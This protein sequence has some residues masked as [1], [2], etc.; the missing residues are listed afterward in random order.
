MRAG[1]D[2]SESCVLNTVIVMSN[3]AARM[4]RGLVERAALDSPPV[5]AKEQ[6]I[7]AVVLFTSSLPPSYGEEGT[8]DATACI[9][10]ATFSSQAD[11]NHAI[12]EAERQRELLRNQ[13][14]SGRT[15]QARRKRYSNRAALRDMTP[16]QRDG[17]SK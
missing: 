15:E 2:G 3:D 12:Y 11:C 7:K 17:G 14:N 5:G 9:L 10:P 4:H 6:S 16:S 13:C 1:D 8:H